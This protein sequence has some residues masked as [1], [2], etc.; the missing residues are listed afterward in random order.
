MRR[1]P[2]T[3]AT[4]TAA[5]AREAF[6]DLAP[7]ASVTIELPDGTF[8]RRE[9]YRAVGAAAHALWGSGAYRLR[10]GAGGIT[11]TRLA[12]P[13]DGRE[14]RLVAAMVSP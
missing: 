11:V 6:R 14:K 7:G 4:E 12:V 2:L 5:R 1:K 3:P 8:W 10:G 9:A 13:L